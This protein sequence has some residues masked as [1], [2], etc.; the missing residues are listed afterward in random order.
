MA[1][2]GRTRQGGASQPDP[3]QDSRAD[4]EQID[5]E[6]WRSEGGSQTSDTQ[7]ERTAKRSPG[8]YSSSQQRAGHGDFEGENQEDTNFRSQGDGSASRGSSAGR[9]APTPI[10]SKRNGAKGS[11]RIG[12]RRAP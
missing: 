7:P 4:T 5:K 6:R 9:L 12:A 3:R 11:G 2:K 10:G 1:S 8:K